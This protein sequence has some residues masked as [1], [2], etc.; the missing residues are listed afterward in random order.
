MAE[1]LRK[2]LEDDDGKL[3]I[4]YPQAERNLTFFGMT[5]DVK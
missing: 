3:K 1:D 5:L 2:V 4:N